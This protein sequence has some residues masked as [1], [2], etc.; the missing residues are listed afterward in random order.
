MYVRALGS[1]GPLTSAP[2]YRVTPFGGTKELVLSEITWLGGRN[3]FLGAAYL[4][5]AGL[6]IVAG[7]VIMV[8]HF[9]CS[10]W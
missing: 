10:K 3:H 2:D 6:C 8:I 7:I 5:T 9:T 4:V 1:C